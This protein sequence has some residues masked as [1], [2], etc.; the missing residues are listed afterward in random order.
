MKFKQVLEQALVRAR[1]QPGVTDPIAAKIKHLVNLLRQKEHEMKTADQAQ[2]PIKQVQLR[3]I[4]K[5]I[6]DLSKRKREYEGY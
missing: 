2:M 1:V 3:A 4:K 5:E 6:A